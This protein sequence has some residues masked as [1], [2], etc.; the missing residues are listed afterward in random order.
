[1]L[2]DY[3][4]IVQGIPSKSAS[5]TDIFIVKDLRDK[6]EY[7]FKMFIDHYK[8]NIKTPTKIKSQQ[9]ISADTEQLIREI[10]FYKTLREQIIIPH[11][12][13]NLLCVQGDGFFN[14]TEYLDLVLKSTPLSYNQ[15]SQNVQQ[16]TLYMLSQV[17][18]REAIDTKRSEVSFI[19]NN[20][21]ISKNSWID[22]SQPI[23]YRF[24]MTPKIQNMTLET[25][26][27]QELNRG[28]DAKGFMNYIFILFLSQYIMSCYGLNQN[29]LHWGN[30]LMDD[31]YIGPSSL[32]SKKY[33]IV[34]DQEVLLI[35]NRYILYMYD[36]D[37]S[38]RQGE[39]FSVLNDPNLISGGNCPDYHPKRD[40]IR[41][42]CMIY[43]FIRDQNKSSISAFSDIQ[44]DILNLFI[45]DSHVR[46]LIEK[47]RHMYQNSCLLEDFD[48][49]SLSCKPTLLK[50]V[51][52]NDTILNWSLT[53]TDY[54]RF[55]ISELLDVEKN[56][57]Q[58]SYYSN[59]KSILQTFYKQI[60]EKNK[61]GIYAN[62]QFFNPSNIDYWNINNRKTSFVNL[63]YNI[64]QS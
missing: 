31:K 21:P 7:F 59:I 6:K 23:F 2:S 50:N 19:E 20:Y 64:I 49:V 15:A 16:N 54:K 11:N 1:M 35:Q 46:E 9:M 40:F 47:D 42:V 32:H 14:T 60:P 18:N 29:D 55:N 22:F 48:K 52:S 58:S 26:L 27:E 62:I 56:M 39:Y 5:S 45:S 51:A 37:R 12:V 17:E 41:T 61:E 24:M 63:I 34:Y 33:L 10:R 25:G 57:K 3:F 53:K 43:R 4:R 13:R 38:V 44:T 30:I 28:L 36:F 8:L